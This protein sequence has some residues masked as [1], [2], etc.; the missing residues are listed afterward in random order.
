MLVNSFCDSRG[1]R[2]RRVS[3]SKS[4]LQGHS[5]VLATVPFDRPH[6]FSISV[7]LEQCLYLVLIIQNLKRSSDTSHIPFVIIYYACASHSCV[8]VSKRNLKCLASPLPEIWLRQNL[9]RGHVTLTTPLLRVICQ[10]YAYDVI[11]MHIGVQNLI[12][13][14]S[15]V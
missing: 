13:L 7:P 14:A 2:V 3:N 4:D 1:M 11:L 12:T 6:R 15:A 9:K 10:P 5:R 8:S